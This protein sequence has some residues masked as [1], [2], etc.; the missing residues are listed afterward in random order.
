MTQKLFVY[1]SLKDPEVQEKVMGKIVKGTP[2]VLV[3]YKKDTV[4]LYGM[5]YPALVPAGGGRIEG[6]VLE[7]MDED[8]IPLDEYETDAYKRITEKLESGT[9]AF[10]YILNLQK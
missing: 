7:V 10:V 1:G 8:F 5:T 6:L 9:E 4:H 3:G 2:D